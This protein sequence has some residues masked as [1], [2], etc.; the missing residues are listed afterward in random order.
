MLTA[1]DKMANLNTHSV[2]VNY[3][4]FNFI[5]SQAF[6]AILLKIDDNF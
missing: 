6:D 4:L 1:F 3:I 5:C 2:K